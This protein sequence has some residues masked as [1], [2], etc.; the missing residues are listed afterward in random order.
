M[1]FSP[2]SERA[3]YERW[4]HA[5]S[6]DLYRFAYR[7]TGRADKADDLLQETF[8]EAWKSRQSLQDPTSVRPWL[9]TILRHRFSR[10]LRAPAE[11]QSHDASVES[12]EPVSHL[13]YHTDV[14]AD[15][16][17]LQNGA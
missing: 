10:L 16:D 13:P 14:L 5:H 15:R 12:A 9:F 7:L 3:A 17:A 4:V 8:L 11:P 1:P 6:A 2:D